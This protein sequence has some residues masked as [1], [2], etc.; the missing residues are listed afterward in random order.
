MALYYIRDGGTIV[1]E[2]EEDVVVVS[3][4][5]YWYAH[6][7]FP[8]KSLS[9]AKRLADS[10]LASRPAS[11]TSIYVEKRG[12]GFDCYA[13]DEGRVR[14]LIEAETTYRT[15]AYFLQQLSGQLPLRIDENLAADTINGIAIETEKSAKSL[16][17]LDSLDFSSVAKPFNGSGGGSFS[18]GLAILLLAALFTAAAGDL[19]LRYQKLHALSQMGSSDGSGKTMYEIKALVKR[20]RKTELKQKM[21][22]REIKKALSSRIKS[23]ECDLKKGCRYE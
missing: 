5:L 11:Y 17:S 12:G 6:A 23:L 7:E 1:K 3:P 14:S 20:Y 10:Y 18:K 22:R 9:K 13:Y 8:T 21:L 4:S 15:P 2:R 19:A 16:P